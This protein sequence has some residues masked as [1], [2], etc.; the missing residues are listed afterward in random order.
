MKTSRFYQD[1]RFL[2]GENHYQSMGMILLGA[3]EKYIFVISE[4]II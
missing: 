4:I 2:A 1:K 3:G